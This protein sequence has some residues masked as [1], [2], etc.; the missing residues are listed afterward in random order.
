MDKGNLSKHKKS[1]H[2]G[3][4]YECRYECKQCEWKIHL[5]DQKS[6]HEWVRYEC[7]QCE[8]KATLQSY[9]TDHK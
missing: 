1:K 9:L 4:R 3:V 5:T 7:D 2:E 8:Y 6:K